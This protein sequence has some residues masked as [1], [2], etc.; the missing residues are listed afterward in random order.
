MQYRYVMP[1][2]THDQLARLKRA[3][4]EMT[5]VL[6][7]LGAIE[8]PVFPPEPRWR[9]NYAKMWRLLKA[10][11]G[12]GGDVST[13]EWSRLGVDHGYDPRGLGGFFRGTEPMMG[14]QG[15]RRVLTENGRRFIARWEPDF[16][17]YER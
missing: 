6:K 8:G 5:T 10:I 4:E 12:S 14:S 1:E 7:A 11:E 16:G 15:A 17:P 9:A 3:H 13:D 2:I